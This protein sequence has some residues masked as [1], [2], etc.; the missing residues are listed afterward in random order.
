V[1]AL[2]LVLLTPPQVHA[3]D[4][5]Y[6]SGFYLGLRA[7]GMPMHLNQGRVERQLAA[8]GFTDVNVSEDKSAP[9]GTLALGYDLE[10]FLSLE[11][12][13][14]RRNSQVAILTGAIPVGTLHSLLEDTARALNGYGSIYSFSVRGRWELLPK[15]FLTPRVG[16]YYWDT[17]VTVRA[18]G[19]EASAT[20]KG[21]GV[22]AGVGA[23]YRVWGGL[24]LGV[25]ADYFRGSE[26]NTAVLYG[27]SVE[28]RF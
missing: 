17:R 8:D 24:E 21:G 10:P 9:G 3:A 6:L 26:D 22:T 15:L 25:G 14:T 18:D 19:D 28:W 7:G 13:Y 20:H 1:L 27:G 11:L 5:D 4:A 16:G 23:A 2:G 12:G